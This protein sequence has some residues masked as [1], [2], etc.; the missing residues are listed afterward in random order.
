MESCSQGQHPLAAQ[1]VSH[2]GRD[3]TR[4]RRASILASFFFVAALA[5]APPSLAREVT[6]HGGPVETQ[7]H[8]YAIFWGS[9]WN[10]AGAEVRGALETLYK[11]IPGS[12]WQGILTQ[13]WGPEGFPSHSLSFTSYTDTAHD[14]ALSNVTDAAVR[15]EVREIIAAN[16][17]NGW[18]QSPSVNDQFVLLTPP[19]SLYATEPAACGAHNYMQESPQAVY[20]LVSWGFLNEKGAYGDC[21]HTVTAAHE[22][23]EAVVDPRLT[24]WKDWSSSG[25]GEI[26]D[27]CGREK[28]GSVG[29]MA[30]TSLWDNSS[31]GPFGESKGYCSG[32]DY[33]PPQNA[34]QILTEA[35]SAAPLEATLH[36]TIT[37]NGLDVGNYYFEWGTTAKKF[38]HKTAAKGWCCG[39]FASEVEPATITGLLRNTTYYFRLVVEG[40]KELEGTSVIPGS[41]LSFTT[42]DWRP[43]VTT[44]APSDVRLHQ[45]TMNG[46]ANPHTL[47]TTYH[48][49]FLSDASCLANIEKAGKE[50]CFDGAT[51]VPASPEGIGSG[52]KDVAL[53]KTVEGLEP[54]AG[55][56]YRI[57]ATNSEA[58]T[59]GARITV[60]TNGKWTLEDPPDPKASNSTT[61]ADVSCTSQTSCLGVG[62]DNYAGRS[63]GEFWNGT[64][65]A[66]IS[67]GEAQYP[68]AVS[69]GSSTSCWA[70]G[71]KL[72]DAS[73]LVQSWV[74]EEGE[75]GSSA[76]TKLITP[77]GG[78]N[79]HVNGIA[80]TAASECTAVGYYLKEGHNRA[81]VER[82]KSSTWTLQTPPELA[83]AVLEDIACTAANACTAVGY[84]SGATLESLAEHW[85]GEKWSTVAVGAPI[86][87]GFELLRLS[88]ISCTA[89]NACMATGYFIDEEF[90]EG[91]P[92]AATYEGS[93]FTLTSMPK[94]SAGTALGDV[95]CTAANSCL[96][97]GQTAGGKST[98]AFVWNGSEWLAQAS[99][100]PAGKTAWLTGVACNSPLACTIVG[101]DYGGGEW[102]S[103]AERYSSKWTLED[104]PDPKASNSTTLADVSCTSQTSCLGVGY[105]NYAGRSLGEFW[106]G[107]KWAL[108]S[109]GEA[110]YPTA[111]SCGSTT[112]CWAVGSKLSDASPL[113]QSWV[114]EEGE[115]G[116]SAATKLITPSGGTNLHV[117]GIAC[118]AASECTAV[119]YYLKEG[120]NRALVERLKSST[121]TLQTPPELADA[122]LEDIACTAANA[123]T[124]VGYRSGATL[125]SLA[126]HWNGEKWSTVSVGAPIGKGFELLRLSAIS[127]TAATSCMATGY[128]ADEEV[129]EGLP[130]AVIYDGS[131][132]SLA[133]FPNL[134]EGTVLADI[135]CTAANSCLT[136]GQTSGGVSTQAVVWNGSEWLAQASPTPAGKTAW[137]TGVACNSPLACT[138]VGWDYGGGEWLS[139]AERWE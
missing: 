19:G 136:V 128:L 32:A 89:A 35:A 76:A 59:Y 120:H 77:S 51:S 73:P 29:G 56:D 69:C 131:K 13:Y 97:V 94:L 102:L 31:K 33:A 57:V 124:A 11:Q 48:F 125:E 110:Q 108:I 63:L 66:L 68:T 111:V 71:S 112:S 14:G 46:I 60:A 98:Q 22:F 62:Y 103:L 116:S 1:K 58:T 87:K 42:P 79:L 34:P 50:H 121:W 132:F 6:T 74:Q 9:S 24:G 41:E 36:G 7:P 99:P 67:G 4:C 126:E 78:T 138:I 27:I 122:V 65:W 70:V 47:S 91:L 37:P 129:E 28:E 44:N 134:S 10:G 105:D 80:C 25:E 117:N 127:C 92:F 96:S 106:N 40:P 61:L 49:D 88:A 95:S 30:V 81:L 26:A 53:G 114:Q 85:N 20:A 38:G 8:V 55:Y 18:P 64:K 119:G 54:W 93:K 52:T 137:L 118:T 130:F 82:L 2:R 12:E 75:W 17:A 115:W 43:T 135:S 72:S 16:K 109:G 3:L 113:V 39:P 123:C 45:L 84:R 15:T 107:T 21:G 100:T 101:W 23:A 90:E 83:D 5:A 104:P 86:G 133:P 139:L